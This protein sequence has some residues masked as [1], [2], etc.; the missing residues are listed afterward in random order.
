[1]KIWFKAGDLRNLP[2]IITG[3]AGEGYYWVWCEEKKTLYYV[4]ILDIIEE[5][6]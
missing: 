4:F 1:M 5:I 6:N 3:N 2:G